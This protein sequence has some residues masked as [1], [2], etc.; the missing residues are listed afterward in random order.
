MKRIIILALVLLMAAIP[1]LAGCGNSGGGASTDGSATEGAAA[2]EIKVGV[3]YELTGGVASY[4]SDSLKGVEMAIKEINDAG[5]VL[6]GQQIKL[7]TLDDKSDAAESTSV[8]ERLMGQEKVVACLGPATSGNFKATIPSATQNK[9]A[10]ISASATAN[11]VTVDASGK[12]L[13]YVFRICFTDDFQGVTMANFASNKL[14]AKK[15]AIYKD[16]SSDYAKGLAS[17]FR[18]TFEKLGGT[19]VAEE[20]YVAKDTDFMAVLTGL[21]SKEF[22]VLFVPGYYEEAGLIIKQARDNGINVPILGADGFDSPTLLELAGATALSNVYFSNHYSSLDNDP[23][24]KQ[25][26]TDWGANNAGASPNAFNA[27]GYD[28]GKFI[29]DAITRAGS[30]DNE[31]IKDALAATTDFVG[32]TGS[33]AIGPDHN[34]IKSVVVIEMQ[35]GQQVSAEKVAAQ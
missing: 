26:I 30:A 15:A 19:I 5:G 24:V 18:A 34:P 32:V 4:G 20:G 23:L 16:T 17:S 22:D 31:K 25:F 2:G 14:G 35:N 1:A 8:A 6:D 29:A 13:D 7:V 3:N 27:L 10:V 21:K 28:L 12:T 9:T 11:D 33:F